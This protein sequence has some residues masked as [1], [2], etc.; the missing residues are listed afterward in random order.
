MA[1]YGY[2]GRPTSAV[3]NTSGA[4]QLNPQR[5][6]V[7]HADP[8]FQSGGY[9]VAYVNPITAQPTCKDHSGYFLFELIII[10]WL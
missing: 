3:I 7:V 6:A 5:A 4:L 1:N 10:I 2:V 9:K 8:S